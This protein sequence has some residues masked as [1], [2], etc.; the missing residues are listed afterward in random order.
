M[1]RARAAVM[2][3]PERLAVWFPPLYLAQNT[4]SRSGVAL[5]LWIDRSAPLYSS[6]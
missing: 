3:D 5:I 1:R 4:V 6:S 2:D